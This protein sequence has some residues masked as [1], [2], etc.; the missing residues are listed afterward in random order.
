MYDLLNIFKKIQ[1]KPAAQN[2]PSINLIMHQFPFPFLGCFFVVSLYTSWN[3]RYTPFPTL[4]PQGL[5]KMMRFLYS[6]IRVIKIFVPGDATRCFFQ[7]IW[8]LGFR[9]SPLLFSFPNWLYQKFGPCC[10]GS[11]MFHVQEQLLYFCFNI[12]W[13]IKGY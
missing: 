9:P 2:K 8:F 6:L 11:V 10:F 1:S 13:I 5:P 4:C 3:L 7:S 12:S